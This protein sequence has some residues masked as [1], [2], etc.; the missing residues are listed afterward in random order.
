MQ[1]LFFLFFL[2][3]LFACESTQDYKMG[4]SG[5]LH[6]IVVVT[7]QEQ[8]AG[9]IGVSVQKYFTDYETVL[10][11]PERKFWIINIDEENFGSLF[12][13]HRSVM[14]VDIKQGATAKVEFKKSLWAKEQLMC[15]IT[16]SS[17]E[18]FAQLMEERGT[19]LVY[20]FHEAEVARQ[21]AK[22]KKFG[23]AKVGTQLLKKHKLRVTVQQDSYI[24]T[25]SSNFVWIRLEREQQLGGFEHQISQGI[26]IY[27]Y[28]YKDTM[29]LN[30][31]RLIEVRDSVTK[32]NLPG[33]SEGSYMSVSTRGELPEYQPINF[34][35]NYAVQIKGL[36]RMENNFMGGPFISLTTVDTLNHRVVTVEG[37]VFAPQFKKRNYLYEVEAVIKSLEFE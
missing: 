26:L 2:T 37:Y 16:A 33:P 35:G 10:P 11:Q 8:W 4:Y 15:K 21:I 5:A 7:S 19:E 12:K 28:D 17:D 14:M 23:P 9:K 34:N 24:A 6:E 29:Q 32:R 25:D 20:R 27:Y 1:K 31:S 3:S 13:T 22:N 18:E 30:P 36:W